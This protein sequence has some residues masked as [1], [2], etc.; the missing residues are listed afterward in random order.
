MSVH[1]LLIL[2]NELR[3]RDEMQ[4][5][6]K[7]WSLFL[8]EFNKFNNKIARMLVINPRLSYH[9]L[10]IFKLFPIIKD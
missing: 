9:K 2:L 8:N 6:P 3:K 5:L 4:G 1:V 7:I 10:C